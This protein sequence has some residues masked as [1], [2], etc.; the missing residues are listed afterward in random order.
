[1][2]PQGGT[3]LTLNGGSAVDD[4]TNQI[5]AGTYSNWILGMAGA[6]SSGNIVSGFT[7]SG[8][9]IESLQIT[10][11]VTSPFAADS[12]SFGF[13]S[14]SATQGYIPVGSLGIYWGVIQASIASVTVSGDDSNAS[15]LRTDLAPLTPSEGGGGSLVM[16]YN[17]I[18]LASGGATV[19]VAPSSSFTLLANTQEA[20]EPT[21]AILTL[22]GAVALIL[23]KLARQ[24]RNKKIIVF[25]E[26]PD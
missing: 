13:G 5:S 2:A 16:T 10:F 22:S 19:Q 3:N 17:G 24:L 11:P 20:P 23:G 15:T 8:I 7:I 18:D 12:I 21:T 9:S 1:M 26:S 25:Y 6:V 4:T 14:A